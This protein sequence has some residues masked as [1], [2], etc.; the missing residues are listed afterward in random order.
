MN[1]T[2]IELLANR[3][4]DLLRPG[5]LSPAEKVSAAADFINALWPWH[6]HAWALINRIPDFSKGAD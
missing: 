4:G 1:L 6:N 2:D 3:S 5:E